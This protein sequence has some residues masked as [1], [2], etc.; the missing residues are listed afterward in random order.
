LGDGAHLLIGVD[1]KKPVDILEAA[2]ND[3][4][5]VTAAFNLNA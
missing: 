5:G 1:A 2:Y 4:A 3:M